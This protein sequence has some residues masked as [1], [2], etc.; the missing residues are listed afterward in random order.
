M[1]KQRLRAYVLLIIVAVIWGIAGP[2]IKFTLNGISTLPFLT[3]RFLIAGTFALG[4]FLVTKY[5]FPPKTFLLALFNG[6]LAFSVSLG[7]L[8][9]GLEKTTVL[10]M[11]LITILAPLLLV[12]GGALFFKDKI[13]SKEK[14]GIAIVLSGSLFATLYPLFKK[15]SGQ[16]FSGN[17]L[18]YMFLI[19]DTTA[20]L[21]AKKLARLKTSPLAMANL[22]FIVGTLTFTPFAISKMGVSEIVQQIT[23]LPLP[24]HLG[25][26]YMALISGTLAYAFYFAGQK[27]IEVSEAAI[28]KYLQPLFGVPLAILWL[29]ESITPHFIFGAVLI[30]IGIVVAESKRSKNK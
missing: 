13:T 1:S 8:F 15:G 27:T 9:F 2:V 10:D 25:V 18:L 19:C 24:Y 21:I 26:W 6:F 14:L 29:G 4:Y 22:G 28:F 23:A 7:L 30:T 12:T 20:A 17:I 16:E 11:T 3:Y 5:K